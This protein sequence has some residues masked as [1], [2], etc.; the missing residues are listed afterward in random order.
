MPHTQVIINEIVALINAASIYKTVEMG[1]IKDWT[2]LWPVC[3]VMIVEDDSDHFAHSGKIRDIQ[4]FRVTSGV[5]FTEQS[6]ADAVTQ[7]IGIRDAIIPIFQ[8]RALL[9]GV[10]GVQD[11]RVKP[12]SVKVSFMMIQGNDYLVH[13]FIVEVHQTYNMPIGGANA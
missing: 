6:P 11:S 1:A 5:L 9:T 4:G 10:A 2:D 8:Q 3:E 7:F 13:E 12:H